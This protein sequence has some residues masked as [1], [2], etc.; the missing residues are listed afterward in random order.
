MT[1]SISTS[2]ISWSNYCSC[3][4]I[5]VSCLRFS[6]RFLQHRCCSFHR[7]HLRYLE[8]QWPLLIRWIF[9]LMLSINKPK[10]TSP[11]ELIWSSC[12]WLY[13]IVQLFFEVVTE[14]SALVVLEVS[15]VPF[16]FWNQ[17]V[18]RWECFNTKNLISL[19]GERYC[20]LT[21]WVQMIW[22]KTTLDLC[23]SHFRFHF[24]AISLTGYWMLLSKSPGS[25][26]G[27]E[28]CSWFSLG[29]V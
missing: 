12:L 3:N 7:F 22:L 1:K 8:P 14:T 28:Y 2:L 17:L 20:F 26:K 10:L 4:Y 15:L 27:G 25:S 6:R 29:F 11:F 9:L 23:L 24:R 21:L 18:F 13:Q 19:N 5:V 16:F